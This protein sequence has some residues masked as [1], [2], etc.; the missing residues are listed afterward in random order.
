M[1]HKGTRMIQDRDDSQ[2]RI[3]S[4]QFECMI[5]VRKTFFVLSIVHAASYEI[6]CKWII[7]C[8]V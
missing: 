3:A 5:H 1:S 2:L 6:V 8:I 4:N 7:C